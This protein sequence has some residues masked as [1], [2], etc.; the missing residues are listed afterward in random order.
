MPRFPTNLQTLPGKPVDAASMAFCQIA[1]GGILFVEMVS[2][3]GSGLVTDSWARVSWIDPP[4]PTGSCRRHDVDG[5][6]SIASRVHRILPD[7]LDLS[8][9]DRVLLAEFTCYGEA[10][11]V[12]R[13]LQRRKPGPTGR[14]RTLT[15]EHSGARSS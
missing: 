8:R 14:S 4:V 5:T 11:D 6:V 7:N 15:L 2:F 12:S 3:W 10:A 13:R 1:L 9:D